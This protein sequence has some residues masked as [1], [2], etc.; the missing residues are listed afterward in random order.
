MH[1]H[2]QQQPVRVHRDVPLAP[3]QPLSG[4]PA[5]RAAALRGLHA[6]GVDDRSRG[7]GLSPGALAQHDDEVVA[8]ALSIVIGFL[9][10]QI[11][12]A[13]SRPF[14]TPLKRGA[15]APMPLG[16]SGWVWVGAASWPAGLPDGAGLTGLRRTRPCRTL[17]RRAKGG[18]A[19]SSLTPSEILKSQREAAL[20]LP[21]RRMSEHR[22]PRGG[23]S[24]SSARPP[25]PWPSPPAG[26]DRPFG[27][28]GFWRP[29]PRPW[30][31][32]RCRLPARPEPGRRTSRAA[33]IPALARLRP[34]QGQAGGGPGRSADLASAARGRVASTPAGR[35]L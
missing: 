28:P 31:R 20:S 8:D 3:L 24:G 35:E 11:G 34:G 27:Q 17:R 14:K 10:H 4:I 16:E 32:C 7:A 23:A 12:A 13:T 21:A 2:A 22:P 15:H 26:S 29:P 1:D 30:R 19:A 25:T 5:A 6:L 33:A 18:R 9:L